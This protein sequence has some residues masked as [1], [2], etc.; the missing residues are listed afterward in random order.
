MHWKLPIEKV[1]MRY[2]GKAWSCHVIYCFNSKIRERSLDQECS[3]YWRRELNLS[4]SNK[5]IFQLP[6]HFRVWNF[7]FVVHWIAKREWKVFPTQMRSWWKCLK[8]FSFSGT[9]RRNIYTFTSSLIP[10]ENFLL[11]P[12]PFHNPP[13]KK[14][15]SHAIYV[16]DINEPQ[17]ETIF[18]LFSNC[19]QRI[20]FFAD[21]MKFFPAA[22]FDFKAF[23]S[24]AC[25]S[26]KV[27]PR[28][29]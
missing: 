2:Y 19:A 14:K 17:H 20:E 25:L 23:L 16:G 1:K 15:I 8:E 12:F 29:D 3:L 6:L 28:S 11:N 18:L 24:L 7:F 27:K 10:P 13:W 5:H 4:K 9:V 22:I 21:A 26:T